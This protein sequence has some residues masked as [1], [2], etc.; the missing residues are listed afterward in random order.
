MIRQLWPASLFKVCGPPKVLRDKFDDR[1]VTEIWKKSSGREDV[2]E[3]FLRPFCR[4]IQFPDP[5][6]F[7]AYNFLGWIHNVAYDLPHSLAGSYHGA[8]N[9]ILFKQR[10]TATLLVY[11]EVKANG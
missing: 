3:R 9:D 2:M 7:S 1:T 4:A 8:C 5:D 6:Q 10:F 11:G